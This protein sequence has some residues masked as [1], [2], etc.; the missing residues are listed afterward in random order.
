MNPEGNRQ[1]ALLPFVQQQSSMGTTVGEAST[2]TG[3]PTGT[4]M[5]APSVADSSQLRSRLAADKLESNP[6]QQIPSPSEKSAKKFHPEGLLSL[7]VW[8][9]VVALPLLLTYNDNYVKVFPESFRAPL[10]EGWPAPLGL[11]LGLISVAIG[12]VVC[13]S[14]IHGSGAT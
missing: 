6:V 3:A 9:I 14:S 2:E 1:I 5:Q 11:S 10:W 12:Q 13:V 7:F 4:T 8:P